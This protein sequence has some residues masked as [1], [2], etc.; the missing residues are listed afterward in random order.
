MKQNKNIIIDTFQLFKLLDSAKDMNRIRLKSIENIIEVD[1]ELNY[2]NK[3][4]NHVKSVSFYYDNAFRECI[5]I[6][7][8]TS[9]DRY[10][11]SRSLMMPAL[12]DLK[13][14]LNEIQTTKNDFKN[15]YNFTAPS[16]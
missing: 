5:Q 7:G 3:I 12:L 4:V 16:Q 10:D 14:Q 8:S 6:L 13:L 9:I 2:K 1:P 15:K 11:K